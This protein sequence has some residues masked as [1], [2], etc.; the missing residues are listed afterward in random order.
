MSASSKTLKCV[1]G[2]IFITSFVLLVSSTVQVQAEDL[3]EVYNLARQNDPTFRASGYSHLASQEAIEQ[4]QAKYLPNVTLGAERTETNQDIVSSDNTVFASGSTDF[5]TTQYTLTINQPV[6]QWASIVGMR[7]SDEVVKQA[8]AEYQTANQDLILRT[9]ERYLDVLKANNEQ[10]F[11]NA[12]KQAIKRQLELVTAKKI[13]GSANLTDLL[14][15]KAR[16]ANAEAELV[17]ADYKV[18]DTYEALQESTGKKINAL[19]T[20]I[21]DIPMQSPETV[22]VEERVKDA[23]TKNPG[24]IALQ[25]KLEV[26]RQE[27]EKQKAGHYPT[28]DLVARANRRETGGTLFGG[29]SDVETTDVLLRLN[30][31]LYEGGLTS[32]RSREANQLF[33]KAKE[34]LEKF[35]RK[36]SRDTRA[37]YFGVIS[38]RKRVTALKRSVKAQDET[39]KGKRIGYKHKKYT[40]LAVL[41]AERDLSMAKSDYAQAKH[42]YL[43]NSLRLEHAIGDLTIDDIKNLNNWFE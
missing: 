21:K 41:D 31:P 27:F 33:F 2:R 34:D 26:S 7:Q 15:A 25:H 29:G 37:A 18:K 17:E 9:L 8:D 28:L 40:N 10:Q 19:S 5:P 4:A 23:L 13:A 38:A 22:S 35:R 43:L 20:L 36:I 6:F 16:F 11:N 14:D 30:I 39:L 42:D 12:E 3:I 1:T 24:I 32:S